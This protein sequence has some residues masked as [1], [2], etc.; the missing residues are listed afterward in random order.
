M[1]EPMQLTAILFRQYNAQRTAIYPSKLDVASLNMKKQDIFPK[2]QTIGVY[3]F[4]P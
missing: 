3:K 1:S 2:W 4:Q